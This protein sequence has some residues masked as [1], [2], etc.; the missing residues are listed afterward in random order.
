MYLLKKAV[1]KV[2]M[3]SEEPKHI[4]EETFVDVYKFTNKERSE[5]V[6]VNQLKQDD[7]EKKV[8]E[9][10]V[11]F[12]GEGVKDAFRIVAINCKGQ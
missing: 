2:V 8:K 10:Y 12:W 9:G 4:Y 5:L 1:N 7:I 3:L 11:N 6:L